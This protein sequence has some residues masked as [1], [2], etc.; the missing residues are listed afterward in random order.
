MEQTAY[1]YV[2]SKSKLVAINK[3]LKKYKKNFQKVCI[4]TNKKCHSEQ[5]TIFFFLIWLSEQIICNS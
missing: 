2:K 5:Y 1:T 3:N 4:Y